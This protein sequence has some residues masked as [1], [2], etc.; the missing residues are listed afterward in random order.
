M[1]DTVAEVTSSILPSSFRRST[2]IGG[3]VLFLVGCGSTDDPSTSEQVGTQ[4]DVA[5]LSESVFRFCA[6]SQCSDY[7]QEECEYYLRLDPIEYAR[8]SQDPRKCMDAYIAAAACWVDTNACD[9][10]RCDVPDGACVLSTEVPVIPIPDT[11]AEAVGL[12]E[13]YADCYL[14]DSE[15]PV[16]AEERA[17]EKAS[18]ESLVVTDAALY[19]HDRGKP[20]FDRYVDYLTCIE[21]ADLSCDAD[22]DDEQQACPEEDA[23][24]FVACYP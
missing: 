23:A 7:S 15:D 16:S 13:H 11:L 6:A 17:F 8:F 12:C 21:R 22:G 19:Q 20:C 5:A 1:S 3:A 18:C 10:P 4:A 2:L 24:F 14:A 9:D